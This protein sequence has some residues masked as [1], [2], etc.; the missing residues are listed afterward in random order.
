MMLVVYALLCC[1]G[2]AACAVWSLIDATTSSKYMC[3]D[4]TDAYITA[5]KA[6]DWGQVVTAYAVVA[7]AIAARYQQQISTDRKKLHPLFNTIVCIVAA[8]T[9]VVLFAA[10]I[11]GGSVCDGKTCISR[12]AA[13]AATEENEK[14]EFVLQTLAMIGDDSG[15]DTASFACNGFLSPGYFAIPENYCRANLNRYCPSLGKAATATAERCRVYVC[16]NLVPGA[17][18]RY[19]LGQAGL[20]LQLVACVLLLHA[21][22]GDD[23]DIV[24]HTETGSE[25]DGLDT[26]VLHPRD[27]D[28]RRRRYYSQPTSLNL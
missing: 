5:S 22:A 25:D 20:V 15:S 23:T 28:L 6:L 12:A 4:N 26:N 21:N 11:I 7:L 17:T 18:A 16:S 8:S 9:A 19:A 3:M 2:A 27:G 14:R 24:S 13:D 10:A 1:G